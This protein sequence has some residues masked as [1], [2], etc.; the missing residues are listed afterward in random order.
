MPAGTAYAWDPAFLQHDTGE[1][2]TRLPDGSI[3]D[4]VEHHSNNRII[5]RTAQLIKGSGL[6]ANLI[7]VTSRPAT[8]EEIG[9][10]HTP[11]Y[12][13]HIRRVCAAGGGML[14]PETRVSP[15]SLDA[16]LLA[17]GTAMELASAI[18][19]ERAANG[20]ALLRPPGHHAMPDQAMGF[21]L[22]NNV[23]I[24]ARHLQKRHGLQRI[25]IVD[26]DVHHGNGTQHAF[27]DDPDVLFISLHQEDWYPGGWGA[28]EAVGGDAARGT[29]V[30]I[31][32]P[33]G[34]GNLGYQL[35]FERVVE[36]VIRQFAPDA[37]FISAGQDANM[38][39]P[40]GRMMVTMEGYRNL[41]ARMVAIANEVCEGRLVALQEGGYSVL[42]IPFCSLAVVEGLTGVHTGISDPWS[43][44]SELDRA[45]RE[46]RQNQAEAIDIVRQVQSAFWSL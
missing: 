11:E 1:S 24:A 33:P 44:S 12:I 45:E 15:G 25:A 10:Y 7:P 26:W 17:A 3:M 34:A 9:W 46:F 19:D 42:Y 5:S 41:T 32:L 35:A 21:C 37:I 38:A 6:E 36:P 23:V 28:A 22:F 43:G 29:T 2:G 16:A 31:P 40:L 27:W 20:Y 39:D 4:P 8:L 18:A 14:D 13:E 30:N